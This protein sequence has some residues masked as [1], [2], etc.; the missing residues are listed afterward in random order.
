MLKLD[1]AFTGHSL[2]GGL[3]SAAAAST[4]QEADIYNAAGLNPSTVPNADTSQIDHYYVR[5]ELLNTLQNNSPLP[6][7]VGTQHVLEPATQPGWHQLTPVIPSPIPVINPFWLE[8]GVE[9]HEMEEVIQ[10]IDNDQP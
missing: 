8:H 7:A 4:G 6:N 2:G 9:I 10:A 5:G 3:A 1:I